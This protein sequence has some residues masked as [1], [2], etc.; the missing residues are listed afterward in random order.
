MAHTNKKRLD[1]QITFL[2]LFFCCLLFHS[3]LF[4]KQV[5]P[6][7]ALKASTAFLREEKIR[8]E[9]GL[10]KIVKTGAWEHIGLKKFNIGEVKEIRGDD[11]K[12]LAFV[13]ELEPE[14][15]IITAADSDIRPILGYSF[16]GTFPFEDSKQNVLLHLV[17]WDMEARL[18]AFKSGTP[19]IESLVQSNTSSWDIYTSSDELLQATASSSTQWGPLLTTNWYQGGHF[20]DY[21]PDDPS[22]GI[23][24]DVGCVATAM[25][26]I[27]NYWKHPGHIE[28]PSSDRYQSKGKN[29]MFWIP[30]TSTAQNY[31]D[32]STLNNELD[33]VNYNNDPDEEGY[34]CFGV[35]IKLQMG[36]SSDGSGANTGDARNVF[37]NDLAYGSTEKDWNPLLL[38]T[39]KKTRV[40]ENIKS[41]WPVQLGIAHNYLYNGHSVVVD[42]YQ[43]QN[44]MFHINVGWSSSS[45]DTWYNI[46]DI[47]TGYNFNVVKVVVY[48]IAPYQGWSQYGSDEKNSFSTVYTYPAEEPD[49]KWEVTSPF[50]SYTFDYAV[51]GTGNKIYAA[52]SPCDLGQ[53]NPPY[54]C[55]IDPYG[56]VN[57]M[58]KIAINNSDYDINYLTQ[59][60]KGE[61][62]FGTSEYLNKTTIYRVD[63][64]TE[65]VTA[66]LDHTSP[67]RGIFDQPIKV[68]Q[69]NYLYFIIEPKFVSNGTKFYST[70]RSGSIRWSHTFSSEMRFIRSVA[71]IDEERNQVYLNYYNDSLDKS[72]LVCFNRSSGSV[73]WTHTF[74]GTHNA[75]QMA[76]APGIAEDGTI[77]V[78]CYTTLYA[79]SPT[80]G[81]EIWNHD[82]YPAYAYNTPA[83]GQDGTLYVNYG[84][85]ISSTWHPLYIRALDPS[86]GTTNWE[87]EVTSFV[88]SFD[89]MGD[90][91]AAGNEMV[92]FTYARDAGDV[93][94]IGGL[95]D[96]GSS[97]TVL[98]D[99]EYGGEMV[100]GPGQTI[101]TV[102]STCTGT[103]SINA[104]SIGDR[105]DPDGLG[106]A[107]TDNSSP[108]MPSNPT[109]A[110]EANDIDLTV[111]LSWNCSDPEAHTLK[112]SLFVGESGYDMVP[113][114]TNI[115]STSYELSGLKPAT[116]YAWKILATDGQ[117]ISE[118][119][120]WVFSTKPPNPDLS[121]DYFINFK[122]FSLLAL[123]WMESCSEPNWC[124]G[125][126]L[127]QDT[128]VDYNDLEIICRDWL[129]LTGL[130][131]GLIA[132]WSFDEG[133]GSTVH[134]YSGN[135][136]NG[137]IYGDVNWIDGVSG[138][139]LDFN[140]VDGYVDFGN[141]VGNFGTEDFSVVFWFRTDT[142]RWETVMGKRVF[143]GEHSFFELQ[144]SLPASPGRMYVELYEGFPSIYGSFYSNQRLDDNQWHLLTITRKDIEGR[145]YIDGFLDASN[146]SAEVIN[147]SN[148]ASF[149]MGNGPCYPVHS[150]FF[151]GEL[152]EVIIYNRAL[153][154]YE[155]QYLYENP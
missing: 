78:G 47:G 83:I 140:G 80:N 154:A 87:K 88:S 92:G 111:T 55:V 6:D 98:W 133:T 103:S 7:K 59:N 95:T 84:K 152:D 65:N 93:Q 79:L 40:I 143:C 77:Y 137:E 57:N 85:M 32:F 118:S 114:D 5:G 104:L 46:P 37:L 2:F 128:V 66:I 130:D 31:P 153:T 63:P 151:S 61:V 91:Y 94:H 12:V 96:N 13:A 41:G 100:F 58:K 99:V 48:D 149:L 38:W 74:P 109:P 34:L 124:E 117:A 21:C 24:S 8:E 62:F 43:E 142:D 75:S 108:N 68:D 105:G 35:G 51:V 123:H 26:Q 155:I 23:K 126:D 145:L 15:F 146:S 4:A 121:G 25:A 28:F 22:T 1:N 97:G 129:K 3:Q 64:K 18:K 9:R 14:G 53:G 27:V 36:Y 72:Y 10:I 112:Y 82:F 141:T 44:D 131:D 50:S 30:D 101:Y 69:D 135:E 16:K 49:I 106:M 52:L 102:E 17:Q 56:N 73:E 86:N 107:Y 81:S 19:E 33:V 115:T 45:T 132:Y 42:G 134:D 11:G 71:A 122:D 136:I 90:V 144:M 76:G 60:H 89:N 39:R 139:A 125:S 29:G 116:G 110:D 150:D 120:L 138:K 148:S 20:N 67:D 54:I 147:M 113:V 70:Y 119:P 127:N